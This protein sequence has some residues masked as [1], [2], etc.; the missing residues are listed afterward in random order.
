MQRATIPAERLPRKAVSG[1]FE[2]I[3]PLL[4]ILDYLQSE[5]YRIFF[6]VIDLLTLFA[7]V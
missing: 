3:Q 7:S 5:F 6:F 4:E 2:S 1:F